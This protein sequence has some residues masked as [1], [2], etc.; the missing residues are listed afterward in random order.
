MTPLQV[1][2]AILSTILVL[3][4]FI[5]AAKP[6]WQRLP[7]P[8]AVL[9]PPAIALTQPVIDLLQQTKTWAD[10]V[11][12]LIAATAMVVVGLFPRNAARPVE[13]QS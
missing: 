8:V 10:L 4:R 12:Q 13:V 7:K 9:L 2:T 6:A 5:N 1:A 3:S 11:T